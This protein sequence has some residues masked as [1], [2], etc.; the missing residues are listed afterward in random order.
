[1]RFSLAKELMESNKAR[2]KAVKEENVKNGETNKRLIEVMFM[3]GI[4]CK[5]GWYRFCEV[6]KV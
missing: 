2:M 1:M 3:I 4:F 6:I 5:T